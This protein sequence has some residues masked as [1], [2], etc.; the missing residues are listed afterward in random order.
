MSCCCCSGAAGSCCPACKGGLDRPPK[1]A[2]ATAPLA[3]APAP[4][5][6]AAAAAA[7][8]LVLVGTMLLLPPTTP[9]VGLGIMLGLGVGTIPMLAGTI[10]FGRPP[11]MPPDVGTMP[12]F[13][14]GVGTMPSTLLLLAPAAAPGL[15]IMPPPPPPPAA[16]VG[17]KPMGALLLIMAALGSPAQVVDN[18]GCGGGDR[19]KRKAM[20]IQQPDAGAG[21]RHVKHDQ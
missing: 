18:A 20:Q 19:G 10:P 17:M 13:I 3:S 21:H 4:P 6:L 5:P 7:A 11:P 8:G 14:M 12:A 15:G 1:P 16:L 9:L 2:P